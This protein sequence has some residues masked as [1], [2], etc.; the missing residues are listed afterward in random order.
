M[1]QQACTMVYR[2]VYKVYT[3]KTVKEQ[4]SRNNTERYK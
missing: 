1:G 2:L 3:G 4:E